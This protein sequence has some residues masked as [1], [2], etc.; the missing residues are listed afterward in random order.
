MV[1]CPMHIKSGYYLIA[2]PSYLMGKPAW[3]AFLHQVRRFDE[4][5]GLSMGCIFNE[6]SLVWTTRGDGIAPVL[7][8]KKKI[9]EVG[10]DSGLLALIPAEA[11][12]HTEGGHEIQSALGRHLIWFGTLI[13]GKVQRTRTGVRLGE[14]FI[15]F[16]R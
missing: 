10:V 3:D 11:V 12:L 9:G 16:I 1:W 13:G 5:Q 6:P 4:A 2:D 7:I 15:P 14:L 8:K